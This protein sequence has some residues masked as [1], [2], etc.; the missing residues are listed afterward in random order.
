LRLGQPSLIAADWGT[1]SLR[2]YLLDGEGAILDRLET[3]QGI[4]SVPSG[5]YEKAL[6]DCIAP[7]RRES[8]SPPIFLSGMIGSR[9][10][11]VEAPYVSCP[12]GLG[13]I[14]T[15]IV[16]IKTETLGTIGLAPGVLSTDAAGAPDVMRGEEA[17]ILGALL[18]LKRQH[19]VFVLPG[20][21]SKWARVEAGRIVAFAT[22]MTGDIFGALRSHTILARLIEE[23]R[24]DDGEG[25]GFNLGVRAASR[26]S[27]PGELL[28]AAFMTR[29]L[30]LFDKLKP[31]QLAEYLS[32]LLIGAEITAGAQ[33][34]VDQPIVI[35]SPALTRRYQ[36]AGDILGLAFDR[37]PDDCV[38]LGQHA[39]FRRWRSARSA[40]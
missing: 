36:R 37:A 23:Q 20:T 4:Q 5:A 27:R 21:H 3:P 6:A 17:Q 31:D 24:G 12:A 1:T 38:A 16:E 35:G 18:A 13:E 2:A 19:G 28:H 29:T 14:A 26:L 8:A 33:P 30:G 11:W 15:A 32:G 22:Y 7:W 10:G 9:Q 25:Q 34:G 40:D 39:L